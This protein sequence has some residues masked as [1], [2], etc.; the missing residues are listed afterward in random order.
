MTTTDT[1]VPTTEEER[2]TAQMPPADHTPDDVA[3]V[4]EITYMEEH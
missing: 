4:E 3:D 1:P 2:A